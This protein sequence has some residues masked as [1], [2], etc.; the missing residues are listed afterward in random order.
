MIG[1]HNIIIGTIQ[2]WVWTTVY[3]ANGRQIG[4]GDHLFLGERG[5]PP[6][7]ID[8][9]PHNRYYWH[10]WNNPVRHIDKTADILTP[11]CGRLK[12]KSRRPYLNTRYGGY[13]AARQCENCIE[14]AGNAGITP[15]YYDNLRQADPWN[16]IPRNERDTTLD[17]VTNS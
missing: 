16:Q 2:C 8:L 12:S 15:K 3:G 9:Q 5:T 1:L 13:D 14:A 7:V 4:H 11:L 10:A 17:P 6:P